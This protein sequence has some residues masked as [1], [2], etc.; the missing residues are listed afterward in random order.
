MKVIVDL[1]LCQDHGQCAIAAPE[2]FRM[3]DSSRLVYEGDPDEV[4][5]DVVQDAIDVCPVQAIFFG[6]DSP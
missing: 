4:L 5:R 6:E 2:V 1:A 3:D